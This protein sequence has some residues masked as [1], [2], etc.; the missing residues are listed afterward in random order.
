MPLA[1]VAGAAVVVLGYNLFPTL[2]SLESP[3]EMSQ[4]T[5]NLEDLPQASTSDVVRFANTSFSQDDLSAGQAAVEELLKRGS[6]DEAK[7]ALEKVPDDKISDPLITF[8]QGRLV[9]ENLNKDKADAAIQDVSSYWVF[10]ANQGD[11][12]LY[13]N[14]LGFA[15][16]HQNRFHDAIEAW[17]SALTTLDGQGEAVVP[18]QT[19]GAEV[20][21]S[22]DVPNGTL[23]NPDAL[24]AYAGIA[25][26]LAQLSV[27]T[28][29]QPY[30][31]LSRAIQIQQV[32]LRSDPAGF[33]PEALAQNWLWTD[34]TIQEWQI[35]TQIRPQ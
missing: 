8:L 9:W 34:S 26:A 15:Y 27:S 23:S 29:S 19:A 5:L 21:Y 35:L 30:D 28:E 33:A 13:Y 1:G 6:V 18:S 7:S 20:S 24:T 12:P 4:S 2:D 11:N 16:Y 32:V 10:A 14:A 25:L 3:T 31:A 22:V 17:Q